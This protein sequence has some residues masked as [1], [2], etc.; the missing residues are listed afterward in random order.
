MESCSICFTPRA[1]EPDPD[2]VFYQIRIEP[3]TG[4]DY[5]NLPVT[6]C[7][8]SRN[9]VS[10][11]IRLL[12]RYIRAISDRTTQEQISFAPLEVDFSLTLFEGEA[13]DCDGLCGIS[14]MFN[15]GKKISRPGEYL[16]VESSITL[17]AIRNFCE[18]LKKCFE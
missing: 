12:E 10:R 17:S 7:F 11:L 14:I 13:D 8:L 4:F 6:D 9:D 15:Y 16:G 1:L 5:I 18:G 3:N 2:W